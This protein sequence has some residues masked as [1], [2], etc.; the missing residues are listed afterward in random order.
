MGKAEKYKGA[1]DIRER[2]FVKGS[3]IRCLERE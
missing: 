3:G 1:C 2:V